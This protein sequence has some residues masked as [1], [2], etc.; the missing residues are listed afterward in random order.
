MAGQMP[1]SYASVAAIRIV[2]APTARQQPKA[3]PSSAA[4]HASEAT[5]SDGEHSHTT[6][7]TN[8]EIVQDAKGNKRRQV[9]QGSKKTKEK[10]AEDARAQGGKLDLLFL[11]LRDG[12]DT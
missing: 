4:E 11:V 2:K 12:A 6:T 10:I 7:T 5:E 8:P 9:K 3:S 1:K